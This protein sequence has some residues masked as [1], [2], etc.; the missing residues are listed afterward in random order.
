MPR[1]LATAQTRGLTESVP[2]LPAISAHAEVDDH[3]HDGIEL[4]ARWKLGRWIGYITAS[5]RRRA[6]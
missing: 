4:T 3:D 5:I 2:E 6:R 1:A